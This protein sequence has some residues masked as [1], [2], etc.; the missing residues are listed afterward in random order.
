M[1]KS[2]VLKEK[3]GAKL[4]FLEGWGEGGGVQTNKPSVAGHGHN[5]ELH[6]ICGLRCINNVY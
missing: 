1:A 2:K 6:I 4:G 5:L 3:Y